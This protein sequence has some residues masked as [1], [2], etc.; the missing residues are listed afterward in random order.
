MDPFPGT[1]TLILTPNTGKPVK[2]G[3]HGLLQVRG[4][5][6][7]YV[8]SALGPGGLKARIAHHKKIS[9]RPRWH[10]DYLRTVTQLEEI[11]YSFDTVRREHQWADILA[12][13]KGV[14]VPYPGFGSSDCK[15]KAHLYFFKSKP[16]VDSFR[17]R[18]RRKFK[19][20]EEVFIEKKEGVNGKSHL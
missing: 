4:G 2:I 10:I 20:H 5:F 15:C 18:L 7:V 8:G 11:W 19:D 16:A 12:G 13:A 1:Y 17:R 9:S 3:K 14:T 6:Y